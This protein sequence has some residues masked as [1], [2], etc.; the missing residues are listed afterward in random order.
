[1]LSN[2]FMELKARLMEIN[3][4]EAAGVLLYWDQAT[5][6]PPGGAVARGR[7]LGTLRRLAHEKLVDPS[8]GR[9]IEDLRPY[10]EGLPHDSDEA[11]LI[12]VARR[13]HERMIQVPPE[14][15]ERLQVHTT[16]CY[17]TWTKARPSDDFPRVRPYLERTLELSR[18]L[19]GFFPGYE[20]IADPLI[21][22][23]DFG[24]KAS[25]VKRL[26]ADLRT[27]L[28]PLVEA[29]SAKP[30]ADDSCLRRTYP[31]PAQLRFGMDLV[32]QLGFDFERGRQDK[33]PHPFMT[34]FSLGDVRITTRVN[35][36]Y[37][38]EALFSTIHEAGHAM[39]EQGIPMELEGTPLA[40]GA[41]SG[42]HESQSRLWEN[43]VCRSRPFWTY[44]YAR[45]QEAFPSQLG[46]V[47]LETFYRA[48]NR[49]VRSLIR[50]D[51]DE[52]TYNLHVMIRFDLELALLEGSLSVSELPEAW[53]ER[54]R[55]D[56]GLEPG[57]DRDGVLQDIHWFSGTIGGAFQCYTLGNLMSAQLFEAALKAHPEIIGEM[58]KGEFSTLLSWLRE[59]VH[60]HGRKLTSSE[61]ME[62]A[63][64]KSLE[65]EPYMRYLRR[66]YGELYGL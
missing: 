61:I 60:R 11:S 19:A 44:F 18:E 31:E 35:E 8:L 40:G 22:F 6:M 7:Q 58:E 50:T 13:D 24:V 59:N 49:V 27:E 34:K 15:V 17:Q 48:I 41:S 57:D 21:D 2:T 20:H 64:G 56:L 45:L 5:H 46:S 66:K 62:R 33:T 36:Q 32:R 43:L 39:Y 29:I 30:I 38:G 16:Q 4:L 55:K 9:L 23:A 10:E 1:M 63:T 51:A 65:I 53:R 54:Y 14:F 3:D 25:E 28:V 52:V 37:L 12:R 42:L 47:S 26:F